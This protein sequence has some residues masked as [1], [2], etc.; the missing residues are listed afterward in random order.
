MQ[1]FQLFIMVSLAIN[2]PIV[3]FNS[4]SNISIVVNNALRNWLLKLSILELNHKGK[5]EE[6]KLK[7]CFS[8]KTPLSSQST[9]EMNKSSKSS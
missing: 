7:Q 1:S 4:S 9:S 5:K 6:I 2:L 3:V 8:V